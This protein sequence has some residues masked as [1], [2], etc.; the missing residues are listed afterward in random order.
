MEQTNSE[1][2]LN[3]NF[4]GP[5]TVK[6]I[7]KL[8]CRMGWSQSELARHLGTLCSDVQAWE[9]GEKTPDSQMISQLEMIFMQSEVSSLEIADSPQIETLMES[10]AQTSLRRDQLKS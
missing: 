2:D 9:Q 8:R 6:S 1:V 5:Q 4:S 10:T 7:K 3:S